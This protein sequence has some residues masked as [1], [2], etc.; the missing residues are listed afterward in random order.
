MSDKMGLLDLGQDVKAQDQQSILSNIVGM[1]GV[2]PNQRE[3][4]PDG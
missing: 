3:E 2:A 1:T 4:D